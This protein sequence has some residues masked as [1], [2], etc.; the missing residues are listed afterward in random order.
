MITI[1]HGENVLASRNILESVKNQHNG[2]EIIT[3]DGRKINLTEVKQALEASSMFTVGRLVI[4]ENLLSGRKNKN[5]EEIL[6]YLGKNPPR[7]E[8]I[9][10]E[11]EEVSKS[12]LSK[13]PPAK[14]TLFRP[15]PVLFKFL[16]SIRPESTEEMLTLLAR[17][18]RVKPPEII[19]Y[20]LV[21][22]FRL[23]LLVKDRIT[24]GVEELDRLADWQKE[25]LARQAKYFSPKQLLDI[26]HQLLEIDSQQ[27]TGQ[28]AFDLTKTLE[29]FL[30]NL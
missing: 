1:L 20:M 3:L 15:E 18:I 12:L 5:Q 25:R 8:L 29:L 21:R 4:I 30:T 17:C 10:W 13:V 2:S 27:K 14:I 6:T 11:G 28:N 7:V 26:Y 23:L 22:Q 16:E 19:F 9:L 24:S